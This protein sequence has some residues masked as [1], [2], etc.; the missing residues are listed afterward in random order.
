MLMFSQTELNN[1]WK[2]SR[3]LPIDMLPMI[4]N[5]FRSIMADEAGDRY[6]IFLREMRRDEARRRETTRDDERRRETTRDDERRRA[7]KGGWWRGSCLLVF[8]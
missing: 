5:R 6:R 8:S 3:P 7:T 2:P 1:M 4:S